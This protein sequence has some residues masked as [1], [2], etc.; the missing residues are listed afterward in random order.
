[1]DFSNPDDS[2]DGSVEGFAYNWNP[3]SK[4]YDFVEQID[5]GR[6]YWIAVG[7]ECSLTMG[8]IP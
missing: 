5:S 7:D 1:M 4:S 6:G 8:T 3:S 2:P